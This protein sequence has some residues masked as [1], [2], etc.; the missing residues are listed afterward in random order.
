MNKKVFIFILLFFICMKN[1]SATTCA[2]IGENVDNYY[3]YKDELD[4]LDCTDTSDEEVV[5]KCNNL[6]MQKNLIVKDLMQLNDNKDICNSKKQSVNSIIK[7][8][9]DSCGKIFDDNFTNLIRKVMMLFYIVGPILLIFFGSYD[10]T[11]AV[12]QSDPAAMKKANQ[13]FF[14][15]LLAT[16]LLF[17]TPFITD[18]II[19][20]NVSDYYLSGNAYACDYTSIMFAKKW[21]FKYVPKTSGTNK[22]KIK[23]SGSGTKV[24]NINFTTNYSNMVYIGGPLPLPFADN[25]YTLS[26][27]FGIRVHPVSGVTKMHNGV[28]L[29]HNS[30]ANAPIYAVADGVVTDTVGGCTVGDSS[31]GG[32]FGNYVQISHNI[33]GNEFITEYAHMKSAPLVST[34]QKVTAGTQ[35]GYQGSTGTSTGE[36][37]HFGVMVNGS[38]TDPYYYI[39]GKSS[40]D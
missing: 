29:A 12:V 22:N 5:S 15:R 3:S 1:V 7:E 10:Y 33:D 18:V 16:V 40:S 2:E 30:D 31:C 6:K 13:R 26:S 11:K 32:G 39:A 19:S 38:Y 35:L 4:T 17:A 34:G 14:K 23:G 8:N 20:F 21:T 36:H 27:P 24:N 28:D 25:N 37:L 9:K